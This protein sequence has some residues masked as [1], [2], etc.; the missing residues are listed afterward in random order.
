MHEKAHHAPSRMAFVTAVLTALAMAV[1]V[2]PAGHAQQGPDDGQLVSD[3]PIS[4][5][6]IHQDLTCEVYVDNNTDQG[7]FYSDDA[8]AT[9]VNIGGTLHGPRDIAAGPSADVEYMPVTQTETGSGTSSDPWRIETVVGLGDTGLELTQVDTY[10]E[11]QDRYR[12]SITLENTGTQPVVGNLY[13]AGDCYLAGSDDGFGSVDEERGSVACTEAE[14]GERTITFLPLTAGSSYMEARYNHVWDVVEAGNPFPDTCICDDFEDNGAGISWPF[15]LAAGEAQVYDSVLSFTSPP[16]PAGVT[17]D[18]TSTETGSTMLNSQGQATIAMPAGDRSDLTITIAVEC[19][20]GGEAT[21]ATLNYAGQSYAMTSGGGDGTVASFSAIVPS[22]DMTG[23]GDVDVSVQCDGGDVSG[24]VGRL[25]LYDPSGILTDASTGDPVE[26]AQVT[27]HRVP[28]WEARTGPDDT[29]QDTCESNLSRTDGED[30]SQPAP[31]DEGVVADAESGRISPTVNPFISSATGYYGWDVAAGC[32]YVTVSADGYE[33][34]TSPVV[35]VPPEVTDLDLALTPATDSDSTP[36]SDGGPTQAPSDSPTQESEFEGDVRT[37]VRSPDASATI[38]IDQ[39][40]TDATPQSERLILDRVV[41]IDAPEAS[42]GDPLEIVFELDRSVLPPVFGP[43][44]VA[45]LRDGALVA[46]CSS[47]TGTAEPDP[48]VVDSTLAHGVVAITVLTSRAGEWRFGVPAGACPQGAGAPFVDTSDN[49]HQEAIS[50]LRAWGLVQGVGEDTFAPAQALSRAEA[51]SMLA[52]LARGLGWELPDGEDRFDDDPD[53]PRGHDI[54]SLAAAGVL[55][56]VD[57]TSFAP[58]DAL[59]RGEAA[60]V[61]VRLDEWLLGTL[62]PESTDWFDD[63]DGGVHE[64]SINA[65]AG[66]GIV[67]GMTP[68]RFEPNEAIRRDQ[69]ASMFARALERLYSEGAFRS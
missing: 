67:L 18:S 6:I 48:C 25:V 12:T 19:S 13:R 38:T 9:L 59:T 2:A 30:W 5:L 15:D 52:R 37:T 47:D 35:G 36:P 10:V 22:A 42:S 51:A 41:D 57:G 65:A 53:G 61:L 46:E 69:A 60:S 31:T 49:F 4:P 50:C 62:V 16:P 43:Q 66:A 26:G 3:G 56:G 29:R 40:R 28:G 8:C 17:V 24:N 63:D 34:L 11:G 32:W 7:E 14:G 64:A 44:D 23:S 58:T 39:R 33:P 68:E 1:A 21:D 20:D 55:Q 27:L 54:E 45:V